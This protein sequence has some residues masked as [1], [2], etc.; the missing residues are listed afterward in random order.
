MVGFCCLLFAHG[1][2]AGKGGVPNGEPFQALQSAIDAEAA[3]RQSADAAEQSARTA[4]DAVEAVLR[5]AGDAAL[6]VQIDELVGDVNSIEE[7]VEALEVTVVDLEAV[8]V[9]LQAQIQVLSVDVE[10][11]EDELVRLGGLVL[12]NNNLIAAM[13]D[14]IDQI[15][16]DLALKQDILDGNCPTGTALSGFDPD[17]SI[18]CTTTVNNV[19]RTTVSS[20]VYVPPGRSYNNH[21]HY[22]SWSWSGTYCSSN[23]THYS[24][25]PQTQTAIATCPSNTAEILTSTNGDWDVTQLSSSMVLSGYSNY[26]GLNLNSQGQTSNGWQATATNYSYNGYNLYANAVCA[27]FN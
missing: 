5:I 16:A 20:V 4:A 22:W 8:D 26:S 15:S 11:N 2:L 7:R 6:Q 25:H 19:S 13:Q 14:Q 10:A 17:G 21:C 27:S 12:N 1:V 24:Y 9:D 3:A 18:S 23:H